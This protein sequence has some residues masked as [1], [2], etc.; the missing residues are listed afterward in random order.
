MLTMHIKI[1]KL[2]AQNLVQAKIKK[3]TVTSKCTPYLPDSN[4]DWS[5]TG[6]VYRFNL[7]CLISGVGHHN[8]CLS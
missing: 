1:F 5:S 6:T 8:N 7:F 3:S 2:I 4:S